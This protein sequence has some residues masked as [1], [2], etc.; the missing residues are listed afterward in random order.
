MLIENN[1]SD[2]VNNFHVYEIKKSRS[3]NKTYL[4]DSAMEDFIKPREKPK[5]STEN[6]NDNFIIT[7]QK[8][9][10]HAFLEIYLGYLK[11]RIGIE[12]Q[13]H[14]QDDWEKKNTGFVISIEKNLMDNS[15][16]SKT[17]LQELL[18]ESDSTAGTS[19]GS[20]R[21]QIVTRGDGI[22]HAIQA[23]ISVTL[24]LRSYFVVAQL[25]PTYMQ[26]TLHQV[27]KTESSEENSSS[28]SL[29]DKIIQI[30]NVIDTICKNI[31]CHVER[32]GG[33]D[34]C[35]SRRNKVISDCNL[36][37]HQSYSSTLKNLKIYV[38]KI[39]SNN[40]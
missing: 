33:I 30:E 18:F 25:H 34:Y 28:I 13:N 3:A 21:T 38:S 14:F 24:P 29:H 32:I 26:I 35:T 36:H 11:S 9:Y 7:C 16:G 10:I 20:R 22:L 31:W 23:S 19:S 6:E 4:T 15:I 8:K 2:V 12:L 5:S 1:L 40:R 17:K 37:S 27:V 39:V